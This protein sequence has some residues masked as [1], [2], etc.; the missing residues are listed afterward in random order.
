[1]LTRCYSPADAT[2]VQGVNDVVIFTVAGAGSFFSGYVYEWAG[3]RAL[4]WCERRDRA[5]SGMKLRPAPSLSL[6]AVSA[7]MGCFALLLLLAAAQDRAAL[8]RARA[9]AAPEAEEGDDD[10]GDERARS[11]SAASAS[12]FGPTF[13]VRRDL[14]EFSGRGSYGISRAASDDRGGDYTAL[15]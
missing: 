7:L 8:K 15:N 2:R 14:S 10:E 6:R 3:W 11:L 13:A 5:R 4:V 1:M 9:A 12:P